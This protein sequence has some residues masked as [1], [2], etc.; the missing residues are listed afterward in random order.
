MGSGSLSSVTILKKKSK[1]DMIDLV[2]LKNNYTR[3]AMS[4]KKKTYLIK[5][6]RHLHFH[7]CVRAFSNNYNYVN[8]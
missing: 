2:S 3:E 8:S 7:V 6:I 5:L 4:K 1:V